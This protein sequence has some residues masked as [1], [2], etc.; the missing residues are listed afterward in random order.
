MDEEEEK[1]AEILKIQEL[2]KKLEQSSK[3]LLEERSKTSEYL[4]RIKQYE[5]ILSEKDELIQ[6]K[7]KEKFE[8]EDKLKSGSFKDKE[9]K[10]VPLNKLVTNFFKSESKNEEE[11]QNILNIINQLKQENETLNKRINDENNLFKQ[12][13]IQFQETI[14]NQTNAIKNTNQEITNSK[15]EYTNLLKE[16]ENLTKEITDYENKKKEYNDKY[17]EWKKQEIEIQH[18]INK[19]KSDVEVKKKELD[20]KENEINELN[21]KLRELYNSEK[22]KK[23]KIKKSPLSQKDFIAEKIEIIPGQSQ[24]VK[25]KI[26]ISFNKNSENNKYEITINSEG[27]NEIINILESTIANLEPDTFNLTFFEGDEKNEINIKTENLLSDYFFKTYKE[28]Y[29]RAISDYV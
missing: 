13:K 6:I 18:L 20:I 17:L 16:K 29:A 8:L 27:Q 19:T 24:K 23:E 25:K 5:M 15:E 22:E 14:T 4:K 10:S 12:Q 11:K 26:K 9:K 2:T 7:S 21:L 28:F 1:K 3:A